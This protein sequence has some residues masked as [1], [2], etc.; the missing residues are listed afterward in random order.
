MNDL[1]LRVQQGDLGVPSSPLGS[2]HQAGAGTAECG[3]VISA[4][5]QNIRGVTAAGSLPILT[6]GEWPQSCTTPMS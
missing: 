5:M 4:L 6:Q 2:H 3:E 1:A